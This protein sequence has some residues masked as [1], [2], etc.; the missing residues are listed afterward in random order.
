MDTKT[1][2]LALVPSIVAIISIVVGYFKDKNRKKDIAWETAEKIILH[3]EE[4]ERLDCHIDGRDIE[5]VVKT[6]DYLYECLKKVR[7]GEFKKYAKTREE[8]RMKAAE[9]HRKQYQADK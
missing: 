3:N 8:E 4:L 9:D 7:T 6:F 5:D 1:L 2:I